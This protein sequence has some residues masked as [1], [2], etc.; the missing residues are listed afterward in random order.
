MAKNQKDQLF[1][2]QPGSGHLCFFQQVFEIIVCNA[3]P[4]DA[5]NGR[6]SPPDRA[7]LSPVYRG[8]SIL[9]AVSCL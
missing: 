4:S 2:S 1:D 8:I 7:K 5:R 9:T 6:I 3:I